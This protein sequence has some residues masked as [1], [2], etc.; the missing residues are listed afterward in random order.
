MMEI[1]SAG[2]VTAALMAGTM[3]KGVTEDDIERAM[4]AV[5]EKYGID[6]KSCVKLL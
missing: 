5:K 1:S 2:V 6:A 3:R 4:T